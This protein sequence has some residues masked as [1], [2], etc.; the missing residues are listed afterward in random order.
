MIRA[1]EWIGD[2]VRFLDQTKLPAEET[3]V[4]TDDPGLIA[5]AIRSLMVRGAPLIGIAAAY[6]VVLAARKFSGPDLSA[7]RPQM[8]STIQILAS[9]RPTATNLFWALARMEKII[10]A[11]TSVDQARE[12]LLAEAL[13]IHAEDEEMCRRIGE[14]GAR[15]IARSAAVLTHCNTG[16]LATGGEGTAQSII[17]MAHRQGKLSRVYADETR[18]LLQGARLTVWELMKAGVDVILI[19]DSTAAYLMKQKKVDCVIVGADRIASNGDTANKVGSYGLA[20]AAAH[21]GV[22]FYVAAP[23][24]TIDPKL[25]SGEEIPI[26]ER[27]SSEVTQ[28]FGVRIAP[29]GTKVYS[30]AFDVTPAALITAII[31]ERGV[32]SPPYDFRQA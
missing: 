13:R 27:H 21:H 29:P 16:A 20:L 26:E 19:T 4:Q 5:E 9:T 2:G 25:A 6:G 15:L 31:T 3:Y 22:P 1:I 30:P 8:L 23:S 10:G 32:H 12:S 17:M 14:N 24:S 28:G 18:P 7:F 11:A